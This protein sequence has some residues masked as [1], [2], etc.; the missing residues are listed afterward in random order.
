[1]A[2]RRFGVSM[3]KDLLDKVEKLASLFNTTRSAIIEEAVERFVHENLQ[4]I[5]SESCCGIIVVEK[6]SERLRTVVDAFRDIVVSHMHIH[7]GGNCVDVILVYGNP[8]RIAEFRNSLVRELRCATRFVP[9]P[10]KRE[11]VA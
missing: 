3:E 9:L 6:V 1:M 5:G 4:L 7:V 10:Q 8:S 2:K 11:G